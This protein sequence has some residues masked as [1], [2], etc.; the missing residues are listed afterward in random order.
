MK[1]TCISAIILDYGGVITEPQD[2]RFFQEIIATL[3]IDPNRFKNCYEEERNSYDNGQLSG[4]EYWDRIL[5]RLKVEPTGSV[6]KDL[7]SADVNSW[8]QINRDMI[9]FIQEIKLEVEKLAIIS[10]MNP[11]TLTYLRR[12]CEWLKNFDAQT[13]SCEIGYNKPETKIYQHCLSNLGMTARECIFVDDSLLNVRG[14]QKTGMNTV[15]FKSFSQ[16][17][18]EL[19]QFYC[20]KTRVKQK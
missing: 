2:T 10:N 1:K 12:S 5:Q 16:F 13:Y 15:H 7:I 8:T 17:C 11:D 9:C 6:V 3:G 19:N 18:Q 14:A 4:E 20:L